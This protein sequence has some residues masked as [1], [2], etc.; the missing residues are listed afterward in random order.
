MN[1]IKEVK[2]IRDEIILSV[3]TAFGVLIRKLE[4][5]TESV[6]IKRA[7]SYE[8]KY[9]I[10]MNSA[11]FKGKKPT[12]LIISGERIAVTTWKNVVAEIMK[13]CNSDTEKHVALMN[14]REKVSG[15]KRTILS[16]EPDK[17]RTP[18]KIAENL[19]ME[20]HY[21]TET[22]LRTMFTRVLDEVGYDYQSIHVSVRNTERSYS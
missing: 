8:T 13:D 14:L 2:N 15:Q 19:Y 5:S 9:P 4:S 20:V 1:M 22:L 11:L 16:K 3:D 21:D 6:E 12:E 17:M 10:T 7:E 18:M